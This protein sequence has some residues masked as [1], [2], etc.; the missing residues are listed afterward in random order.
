MKPVLSTSS[1]KRKTAKSPDA[2]PPV[3]V[4]CAGWSLSGRGL[5]MF[6]PVGTHLERYATQ[7]S[8]AEINSSFH[9]PHKPETYA[10][11][12]RSVPDDFRFSVKIPKVITHEQRLVNAA[13][14]LSVFLSQA[15][16]LL[17]K[18]GC[19][20]VQLPPK[21]HYEEQVASPFFD[22]LRAQYDG[23]VALEP[24]HPSWFTGDVNSFLVSH[25]VA[26]VAADPAPVP[27]AAVPG[28]YASPVY[29]R[30]HGSPRV[31]YS[32]YDTNFLERVCGEL[33][34]TESGGE[35]W[36]IFD[37]T[38]SGAAVPDALELMRM[39][40]PQNAHT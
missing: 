27:E 9:R 2:P 24:R 20:L 1:T 37:N 4:G 19:L 39:V 35:R 28:G 21:L 11:W 30:L 25:R 8:A 7:F 18:L 26:R 6:E 14:T 16:H 36:C 3:R 10:R 34:H 31:Y 5:Q 17:P 13:D 22:M 40:R 23:P 38:A 15:L 12:A 32:S 29:Y 33:Q